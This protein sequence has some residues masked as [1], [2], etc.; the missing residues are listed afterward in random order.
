MGKPLTSPSLLGTFTC[1]TLHL[2]G[3]TYDSLWPLER[4]EDLRTFAPLYDISLA[5]PGSAPLGGSPAEVNAR[6]SLHCQPGC[7]SSLED[8][9]RDERQRMALCATEIS[10][11]P[12]PGVTS[13]T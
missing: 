3:G 6:C 9:G 1:D 12:G 10:A 11:G 7:L 2:R 13:H 5:T 8:G 4:G